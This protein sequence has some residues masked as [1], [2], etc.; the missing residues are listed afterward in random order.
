MKDQQCHEGCEQVVV[1]VEREVF[2]QQSEGYGFHNSILCDAQSSEKIDDCHNQ[3]QPM[4]DS[5]EQD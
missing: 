2:V 3:E 4:Y 1:D 5:L